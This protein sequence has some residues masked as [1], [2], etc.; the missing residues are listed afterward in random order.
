MNT[1]NTEGETKQSKYKKDFVYANKAQTDIYLE[2]ASSVN[3][4]IAENNFLHGYDVLELMQKKSFV[5]VLL[6]LFTGELP[7]THKVTLL[8]RLMV[9]L[10]NL[11]PRHP[12]VKASMVA[13]V[14]KANIEHLLPI[15]L[16]VLGGE[17]NGAK[18]V[19]KSMLFL[20]KH[21]EQPIE[22]VID[23]LS[24]NSPESN[25]GEFHVCPGFGNQYGSVDEFAIKI[26]ESLIPD[27]IEHRE[28]KYITWAKSFADLL[29]QHNMGWLKTGIAAAVFCE[30]GIGARESVG[31]FQLICAPGVFAHGAEQTHKPITAIPMLSDE[32]HVYKP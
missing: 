5:S 31:L 8:E 22:K 9:A 32:Q 28:F 21:L 17:S 1:K 20:Q 27:D 19:E 4:Y 10:I 12:A 29:G 26:V 11:G 23:E 7:E 16:S 14:S 3:P 18:E 15:G 30:L 24:L 2:Q 6:L 13:G 25:V